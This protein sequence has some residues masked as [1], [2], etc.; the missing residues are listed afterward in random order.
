MKR[1]KL[2]YGILILLFGTFVL[3]LM[4]RKRTVLASVNPNIGNST[5]PCIQTYTV[6]DTY[7]WRQKMWP[8]VCTVCTTDSTSVQSDLCGRITERRQYRSSRYY[9]VTLIHCERDKKLP[10][11]TYKSCTENRE[12]AGSS[13]PCQDNI[14][15]YTYIET[16]NPS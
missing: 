11:Y 1:N 15:T 12:V 7:E 9:S 10:W 2:V 8:S 13:G 3:N 14:E 16:C 5:A 4:A 6:E